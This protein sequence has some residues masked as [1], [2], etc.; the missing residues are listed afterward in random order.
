MAECVFCKEN[1]NR[2]IIGFLANN[3]VYLNICKMCLENLLNYEIRCTKCNRIVGNYCND[4]FVQTINAKITSSNIIC[5][6][7]E[8]IYGLDDSDEITFT[9]IAN[10][11]KSYGY[12]PQP[13]FSKLNNEEDNIYLGVELEI[14]GLNQGDVVNRFCNAHGG[15]IFYFKRD[16]SIR[17]AG[18]EIVSHPATLAFHKSAKSGWR[19]LFA[20]FN[21]D[22]FI[23][24]VRTNTGLH[25]HINKNIL[26]D[27]Q[28][29][30]IDLLINGDLAEFFQKIGRRNSNSYSVFN[31]KRHRDWGYSASR[32]ESVNFSNGNT[33]EFRFFN[34]TNNIKDFYASLEM[35]KTIFLLTKKATFDDLYEHSSNVLNVMKKIVKEN[36]FNCLANLIKDKTGDKTWEI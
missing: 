17:G 22:G 36:N 34:G 21:S 20:D 4:V 10:N 7:C 1:E 29:K 12:K 26:S 6:D 31:Y 14:G 33:V 28:C 30:K 24:G 5:S 16:G 11:L 15:S 19:K 9:H 27:S 25:I 23:S 8:S 18:C 13:I 35:V 3:N 2:E 32:Y